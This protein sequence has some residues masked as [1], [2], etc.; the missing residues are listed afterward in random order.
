[1]GKG[2]KAPPARD[3]GKEMT[4]SLNAQIRLAPDL[5]N[6]ESQYRPLYTALDMQS[7][8][9]QLNGQKAGVGTR[10]VS[11]DGWTNARGEFVAGGKPA[12]IP[13]T[14]EE[15]SQANGLNFIQRQKFLTGLVKRNE[16]K[17]GKKDVAENYDIPASRGLIDIYSNDIAPAYSRMENTARAASVA[18]DMDVMSRYGQQASDLIRRTSGNE[19]LLKTLN[20]QAQSELDAGASLDPSLRREVQQSIR[21]GQAARGFG[22]GV[23]DLASESYMTAMQAEQLRRAR[24]GFGMQMVGMNQATGGDPFMALLGRQSSMPGAQAFGGNAQATSK[25][26]GNVLFNPESQYAA[27]I[28]NQSYQARA[29]ASAGN[30]A[31]SSA[32][33]GAGIGAVGALGGAAII[34]F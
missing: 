25:G 7:L 3:Y 11:K 18:G 16:W 5:Y 22:M 24:Q 34:A 15:M 31:N 2:A 23:N 10:T 21:A 1:M 6:A 9:T 27:D 17:A 12:T 19:G 30:A 29:A 33:M 8:D 4:D 26:I 14:A 32:M 28:N 13:L 20:A